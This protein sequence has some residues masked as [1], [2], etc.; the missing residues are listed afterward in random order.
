MMVLEIMEKYHWDYHTYLSQPTWL[1]ATIV[2]KLKIDA[3]KRKEQE[4]LNNKK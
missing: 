2:D 4:Q 3:R 1:I